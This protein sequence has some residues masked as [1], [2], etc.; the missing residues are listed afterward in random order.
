MATWGDERF[1][2][3]HLAAVVAETMLGPKDRAK[4]TKARGE[5][6]CDAFEAHFGWRPAKELDEWAAI[7]GAYAKVS[8]LVSDVWMLRPRPLDVPKRPP[9]VAKTINDGELIF[10]L[11]TGLRVFGRDPSGDSCFVSTLPSATDRAEVYVMDHENGELD[12][13]HAASIASF[14][15]ANFAPPGEEDEDPP[16]RGPAKAFIRRW[17]KSLGKRAVASSPRA[18]F[19][20]AKWMLELPS[21]ETGWAFAQRLGGAPTF[22]TWVKERGLVVKHPVLASY[23]MLAHYFLGNADACRDASALGATCAGHVVPGLAAI[24]SA[25]VDDPARAKLGRLTP[26]VLAELREATAKNCDPAQLDPSRAKVVSKQASPAA[27]TISPKEARERLRRART[28]SPS[29][30]RCPTTLPPT[31]RS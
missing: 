12:G 6:A 17:E 13:A 10:T 21:G 30:R 11:L 4:L 27:R 20:R 8:R 1:A 28:A 14:V 16:G 19:H 2:G 9:P 26:E 3:G 15:A 7:G 22:A 18:L 31:T 5:R 29:S 25:L 23:W 24:V